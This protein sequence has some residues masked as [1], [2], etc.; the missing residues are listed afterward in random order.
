MTEDKVSG[1]RTGQEVFL[2]YKDDNEQVVS[3]FVILIS[4]SET[5]LTFKTNQNTI[6][7]PISRMLK[8][9]QRGGE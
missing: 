4:I 9:K 2:S 6:S 5:L 1:I 3:G 8:L 7:I